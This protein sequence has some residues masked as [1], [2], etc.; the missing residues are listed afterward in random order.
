M[1]GNRDVAALLPQ[2]G[3]F[4]WYISVR[5]STKEYNIINQ[6]RYS[7]LLRTLTGQQIE[8]RYT[9]RQRYR[10]AAITLLRAVFVPTEAASGLEA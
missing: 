4:D 10:Q 9:A 1:L 2:R 6:N 5:R 3:H 7:S 8:D